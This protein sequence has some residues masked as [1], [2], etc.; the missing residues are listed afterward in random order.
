MDVFLVIQWVLRVL[1][2][3]IFVGMGVTHFVPRVRATMTRMIPP[4]MRGPGVLSPSSLVV[5][6]GVA[7]IV[8]GLALL[9]PWPSIRFAAGVGLIALLIAVFPA[10]AYVARH[11]DRFGRLSVPLVPRLVGQIVL[12]AL[13]LVAAI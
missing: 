8:G 7:E 2:A 9:A 10:N 6:S 11:P 4:G 13:V 12:G 3:I 1:L 5:I